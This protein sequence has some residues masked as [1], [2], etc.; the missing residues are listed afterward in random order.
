MN[1]SDTNTPATIPALVHGVPLGEPPRSVGLGLRA[2]LLL[3]NPQNVAA[4]VMLFFV[5]AHDGFAPM[6][7]LFLLAAGGTFVWGIFQGFRQH[8]LLVHGLPAEGKLIAHE[9]HRGS[10]NRR[11]HLTFAFRTREG[12][13][14]A[15]EVSVRSAA[16]LTD[17]AQ[18]PLLYDPDK[19]E[20]ALLLDELPGS[21]RL[22]E[23]G[24]F[25]LT[26][27]LRMI[28]I[29]A[30]NAGALALFLYLFLR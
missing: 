9:T 15:T 19:P 13:D 26:S 2:V 4:P 7:P 1:T 29:V 25:Q 30:W 21:P 28:G 10:S 8:Q 11:H 6:L 24:T 14:V 12:D 17:D 3:G 22:N 18:E 5:V 27:P 20:R 23:A 16:R